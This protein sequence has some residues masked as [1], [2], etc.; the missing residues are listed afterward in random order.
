M[1]VRR[2]CMRE[3]VRD[4]IVSGILDGR[5][6]P[7]TRLKEMALAREFN[8]S[9]APVREALRELQ[10]IGLLETESYRGTRVRELDD[11][12]LR[13]AYELRAEIEE[14]A[15]VRAVPCAAVD[16][17]FLENALKTMRQASRARDRDTYMIA[18]VDFHRRIVAMSGN[19]A[20]LRAWE[21]MAWD[22][23]ARFVARRLRLTGLFTEER[24]QI[25]DALRAGDGARAGA[26]LRG[27]A[28]QLLQRLAALGAGTAVPDD[29]RLRG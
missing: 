6:P 4:A 3:Q 21:S 24:R 14:A 2:C 11:Q 22:V 25:I 28:E 26:L 9:Q 20:F 12:E 8:V 18:A 13:E 23:R 15:A 29:A 1:V 16:L 19:R 27:I 7:G 17:E 5:W 10:A